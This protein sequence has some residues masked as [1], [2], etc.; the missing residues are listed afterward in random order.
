MKKPCRCAERRVDLLRAVEELKRAQ[1]QSA[2]VHVQHAART[3]IEDAR[4]F[5]ELKNAS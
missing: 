1:V 3:L 5:V 4:E 2:V